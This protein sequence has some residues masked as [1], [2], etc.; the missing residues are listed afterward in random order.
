MVSGQ[1]GLNAEGTLVS[2]IEAQTR[3]SLESLFAILKEAGCEPRDI[4]KVRIYLA[5]MQDYAKMNEV[6]ATF[7]PKDPPARIA[8]AVKGL[9]LGALVEIECTAARP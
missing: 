4:L 9:P 2:G 3:Q 1:V 5:N 7:F 6:Y 8:L